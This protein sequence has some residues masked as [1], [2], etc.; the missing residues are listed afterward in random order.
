[1]YR[2]TRLLQVPWSLISTVICYTG[3]L[4]FIKQISYFKFVNDSAIQQTYSNKETKIACVLVCQLAV[5]E[6]GPF[7]ELLPTLP[8][9]EELQ[10]CWADGKIHAQPHTGNVG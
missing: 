5:A 1:M 3:L 8:C 7:K 4:Y 2:Y 10:A 6:R 9:D